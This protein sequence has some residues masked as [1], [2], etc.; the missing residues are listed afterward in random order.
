MLAGLKTDD[1]RNSGEQ[2]NLSRAQYNSTVKKHRTLLSTARVE[3][4]FGNGKCQ[5]LQS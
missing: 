2:N 4:G 5:N 3:K 1:L